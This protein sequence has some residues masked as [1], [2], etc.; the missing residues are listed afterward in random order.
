MIV[1]ALAN[2]RG[3]KGQDNSCRLTAAVTPAVFSNATH[4]W[5]R[6]GSALMVC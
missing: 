5:M 3:L 2:R 1:S 4:S 6:Q